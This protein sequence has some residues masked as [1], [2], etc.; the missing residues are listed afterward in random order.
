V[1]VRQRFF[2]DEAGLE[3]WCRELMYLPEPVAVVFASHGTQDG[4]SIQGKPL[5]TSR[6][7]ENLRYADNILLLH[8]SSCLMLQ[9]G[10][11]GELARA[12]QEAVRFPISGY[13]RSVDWA[14][15]A[16]IEFHYLD[17]VLGRGLSPAIAAQEVLHLIGYAGDK[18]LP[19]SP[20]PAAG[21]RI[22]M[23]NAR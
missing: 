17:M 8:F 19:G 4:L 16:L 5:N 14:A 3:R 1:N 6:L 15:S 13:D 20:Y 21:F 9:D 18:D 11:A 10:K 12:L 22:F 23:P 7:V 2:E